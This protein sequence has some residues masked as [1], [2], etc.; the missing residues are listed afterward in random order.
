ML[1][2]YLRMHMGAPYISDLH[3]SSMWK[4]VLICI[5]TDRD[6]CAMFSLH[7]WQEALLYLKGEDLK[8]DNYRDYLERLIK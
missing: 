3:Y 2:N 6:A 7:D 4:Q 1:L 8:S 5:S